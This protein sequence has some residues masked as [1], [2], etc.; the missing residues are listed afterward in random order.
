M[1]LQRD[2][3]RKGEQALTTRY[4]DIPV[5]TLRQQAD[6]TT[7]YDRA[8]RDAYHWTS[9]LGFVAGL[10]S[11]MPLALLTWTDTFHT[12]SKI[13]NLTAALVVGEAIVDKLPI[14]S[15]RLKSGSLIARITVGALAGALLCRRSQASPW[16][17]ALHGALG[18]GIGSVVGYA[19]R[20][21]A[22]HTTGIPDIVW[23]LLEDG[24]AYR[25]GMNA[26]T[27]LPAQAH[28]Q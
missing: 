16:Q 28:M 1:I 25:L 5:Y 17:G 4:N 13:K 23:A 26:V 19:Y 18:A 27:K 3:C 24:A 22:A 11:M 8:T 9:Q 2:Y 21:V 14:A 10:R 15:S 7:T 12:S 6:R 20:S